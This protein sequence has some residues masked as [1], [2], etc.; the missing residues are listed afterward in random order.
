[1]LNGETGTT[2][3]PAGDGPDQ[4]LDFQRTEI[5]TTPETRTSLGTLRFSVSPC[6]N[7]K[8]HLCIRSHTG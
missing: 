4:R 7:S 3:H 2:G 5:K 1:M 8:R 6:S